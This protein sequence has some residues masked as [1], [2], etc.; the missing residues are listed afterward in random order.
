M[1]IEEE[2]REGVIAL[3]IHMPSS[4]FVAA[5]AHDLPAPITSTLHVRS[6]ISLLIPKS[7]QIVLS[8]HV[9]FPRNFAVAVR[10]I[11]M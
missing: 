6:T 8:V 3:L 9:Y 11:P 2:D 5:V 1:E 4:A 10:R 7:K